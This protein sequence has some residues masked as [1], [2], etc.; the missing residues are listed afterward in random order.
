MSAGYLEPPRL[1]V[2][3][4]RKHVWRM[5]YGSAAAFV[6]CFLAVKIFA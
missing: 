2:Y 4:D 1:V 5:I 3:W 6:C